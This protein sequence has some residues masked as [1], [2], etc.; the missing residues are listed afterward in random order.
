[1][2]AEFE[3]PREELTQVKCPNCEE[4]LYYIQHMTD[5]AFEKN[6]LIQTYFCKKCLY[7]KNE[8][9]QMEKGEPVRESILVRNMDD[10]RTVI[11]RSPEAR[12]IVPEIDAEISPGEISTGEVTTIEGI[13]SRTLERMYSAMVDFEGTKKE[14]KKA[15]GKMERIARWE[16]FPFTLII[17]DTMGMSR[18][19]SSRAVIEKIDQSSI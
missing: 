4:Y 16:I 13:L 8:I 2:A 1:M 11:Y 9:T 6:I 10:L 19:Q 12:I 5:I 3:A 14:E 18:I 7:K 17:E 15:K